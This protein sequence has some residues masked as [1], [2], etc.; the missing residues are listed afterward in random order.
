MY[1]DMTWFFQS[2]SIALLFVTMF[3]QGDLFADVSEAKALLYKGKCVSCHDSSQ[4]RLGPSYR[5]MAQKYKSNPNAASLMKVTIKNGSANKKMP[6]NRYLSDKESSQIIEWIMTLS[7]DGLIQDE[8]AKEFVFNPSLE[9]ITQGKKLFLGTV[10]LTNNGP[11][12]LS[13]HDT[14]GLSGFGGGELASNLSK[15][16]SEFEAESLASGIKAAAF[17]VME[18]VYEDAPITEKESHDI[19][20][21]LSTLEASQTKENSKLMFVGAAACLFVAILLFMNFSKR[22]P[23]KSLRKQL[24]DRANADDKD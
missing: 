7:E 3:I 1:K 13:C 4:K 6:A 24:L 19:T 5:D 8:P 23:K 11:S 14:Q 15:T 2:S 9:A 17:P 22:K 10:P 20:A 18:R 16:F 21:Y 12:C